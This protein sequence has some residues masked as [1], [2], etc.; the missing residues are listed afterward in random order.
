VREKVDT[1]NFDIL[2]LDPIVIDELLSNGNLCQEDRFYLTKIRDLIQSSKDKM[3]IIE[4]FLPKYE[5]LT[6]KLKESYDLI[7]YQKDKLS[8][9]EIE[10][11]DL[12]Y[13]ISQLKKD[14]E[15]YNLEL[16]DLIYKISQ[17]K[18]LVMDR[19]NDPIK[20]LNSIKTILFNNIYKW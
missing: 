4:Q 20:N 17:V 3:N 10:I 18:P 8:K 1:L 12:V 13:N 7:R 15:N 5:L 2:K 9:N 6:Q 19:K 11:E 14:I 16:E